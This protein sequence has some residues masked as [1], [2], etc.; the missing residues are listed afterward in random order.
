M[1]YICKHCGKKVP[2]LTI[3]NCRGAL[4]EHYLE[5]LDRHGWTGLKEL[6]AENERLREALRPFAKAWSDW[7]HFT[8]PETPLHLSGLSATDVIPTTMEPYRLAFEALNQAE[9][10][11]PQ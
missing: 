3:C 5:E 2:A 6:T 4:I 10:E 1:T 8:N 9:Q 11:Q 7:E